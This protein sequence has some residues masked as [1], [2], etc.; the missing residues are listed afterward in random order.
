MSLLALYVVLL[1]ATVLSFSGFASVPL[2]RDDLVIAAAALTDQQLNGS[3]AISQVSPGP[4]GMYVVAVGYF[5]AGVPGAICGLLALCTPAG[6]VLLV[7]R[8]LRRGRENVVRKVSAGIVLASS[9]LVLVTGIRLLPN[10][11]T[12][13]ITVLIAATS[14]VA[15]AFNLL[16]PVAVVAIAVVIGIATRW[17]L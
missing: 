6:I 11:G 16:P 7:S 5:V 4:L 9:M 1:R 3:I 14:F 12:S 2:V 10:L 13:P 15:I 8:L 17:W